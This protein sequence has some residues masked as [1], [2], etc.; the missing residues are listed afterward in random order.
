MKNIKHIGGISVYRLHRLHSHLCIIFKS[1]VG[2]LV[3]G[4]VISFVGIFAD[5]FQMNTAGRDGS[6]TLQD[7]KAVFGSPANKLTVSQP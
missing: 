6:N 2:I 3:N 5:K 1:E 4:A 7:C